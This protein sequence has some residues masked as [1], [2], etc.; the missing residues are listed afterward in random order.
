M[1]NK[2][3]LCHLFCFKTECLLN[4]DNMLFT[5]VIDVGIQWPERQAL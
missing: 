4:G 1:K 3:G 5:A 2:L